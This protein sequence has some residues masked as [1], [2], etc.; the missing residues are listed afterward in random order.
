MTDKKRFTIQC[1]SG[2]AVPYSHPDHPRH[3]FPEDWDSDSHPRFAFERLKNAF[4]HLLARGY[5]VHADPCAIEIRNKSG[6]LAFKM[7]LP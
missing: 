4:E 1:Y 7:E 6:A 2:N 3:A 5:T